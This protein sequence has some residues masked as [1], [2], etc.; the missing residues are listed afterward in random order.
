MAANEIK[1]SDPLLM[2]AGARRGE[3]MYSDAIF[4]GAE[5]KKPAVRRV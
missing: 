3:L 4:S 5:S 2:L 1:Y